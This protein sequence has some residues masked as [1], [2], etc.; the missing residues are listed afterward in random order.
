MAQQGK[1]MPLKYNDADLR[2]A[3]AEKFFKQVFKIK[4]VKVFKNMT[5]NEIIKIMY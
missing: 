1:S 5:R 3:E 4:H 2:A